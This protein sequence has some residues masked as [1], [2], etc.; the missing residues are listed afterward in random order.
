MKLSLVHTQ[1]L[2]STVLLKHF[3]VV[4]HVG[5]VAGKTHRFAKVHHV[6]THS[7]LVNR[8]PQQWGV[9]GGKSD[10]FLVCYLLIKDILHLYL[11][12]LIQTLMLAMHRGGWDL[13]LY[14]KYNQGRINTNH[15]STLSWSVS[16]NATGNAICCSRFIQR[17]CGLMFVV[18]TFVAR[19]I[20][21]TDKDLTHVSSTGSGG[22]AQSAA[23]DSTAGSAL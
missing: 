4:P 14:H 6:D 19:E 16:E 17:K 18:D 10:T 22:R 12:F 5:Q 9:L 7:A 2:S 21:R 3:D 15:L 20:T 1:V 8:A 23:S 11:N 13:F